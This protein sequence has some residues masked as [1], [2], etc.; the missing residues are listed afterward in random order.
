MPMRRPWQPGAWRGIWQS[1]HAALLAL[2]VTGYCMLADV[3][4]CIFWYVY[5]SHWLGNTN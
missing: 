4:L 2:H 1:R 5:H 3:L